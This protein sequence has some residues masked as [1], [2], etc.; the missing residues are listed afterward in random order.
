MPHPFGL[1]SGS[2]PDDKSAKFT[3]IFREVPNPHPDFTNYEGT[4]SVKSGLLHINAWSQDFID[5][6]SGYRALRLYDR[7]KRQLHSVYGNNKELEYIDQSSIWFGDNEF[8]KSIDVGDRRHWS[9]WN[10]ETNARLD[11]DISSIGLHIFSGAAY[12]TLR[13]M[14]IYKFSNFESHENEDI[15]GA[16]SL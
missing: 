5:D 2:T 4:W 1:Q 7:V 13:V 11:S 8:S 16:S 9:I 12:T 6:F 3:V 15:V 14:I 10:K